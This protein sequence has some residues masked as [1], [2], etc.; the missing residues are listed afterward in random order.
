MSFS[1]YLEMKG[2]TTLKVVIDRIEGDLAVI[3]LSDDDS[4]KFDLPV[5][6]MPEGAREG[7]HYRMTFTPDEESRDS[8]RKRIE[9]LYKQLTGRQNDSDER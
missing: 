8:E 7:E 5:K 2:E 6:Y 9:D 1:F 3:V 4:V